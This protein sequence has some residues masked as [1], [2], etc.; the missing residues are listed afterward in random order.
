MLPGRASQ[1][2]RELRKEEVTMTS[3]TQRFS[4]LFFGA[5]I[6]VVTLALFLVVFGASPAKA[7][8]NAY[9]VNSSSASVSVVDTATNT[10][11]ATIPVGPIPRAIVVSPD[12]KFLYVV[13][14][15]GLTGSVSVVDLATNTVIATVPVGT[16]PI[17]L[18][19]R[20]DGAFVYVAN[21]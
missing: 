18:V 6:R 5:A 8:V 1:A 2:T 14:S 12:L 10:V 15:G 4:K 19:I 16:L 7:Q 20:P 9:V 3:F 17:G 21:H 13:N 11:V